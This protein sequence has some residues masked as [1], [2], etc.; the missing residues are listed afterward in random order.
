MR[1]IIVGAQVSM[2]GV[3]QAPGGPT[4]D[5]TRGFKFGG[6][7]MP[8]FDEAAGEEIDRLFKD[9]FDLLLGRKTYEIFAAYWPYYN[10]GAPAGGIAELFKQIKKYVV[11]RS[12]EVDTSWAGSVLLR[13]IAQVKRLKQEDGP[14]L[15]T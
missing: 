8:Y 9:K 11:S 4:E 15:V 5:P 7:S 12:G 6:W 1:K 3:M 10:E 14:N 2:D 13:D